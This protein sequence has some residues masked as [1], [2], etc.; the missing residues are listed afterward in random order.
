MAGHV[1]LPSL[2]AEL[3]LEPTFLILNQPWILADIARPRLFPLCQDLR[4][5]AASFLSHVQ[6]FATPWSD[7]LS[8]TLEWVAMT[9]CRGSSKPG[10]RPGLLLCRQILYHLSPQGSPG[11]HWLSILH[12]ACV[13]MCQ[14]Q[15]PNSF[16]SPFPFGVHVLVL[17]I[18]L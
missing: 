12:I 6:L 8:R 4:V 10:D 9:S 16:H 1:H 7:P 17:Y 13:C 3:S 15:S 18:C 14:F 5:F 2:L 11:S